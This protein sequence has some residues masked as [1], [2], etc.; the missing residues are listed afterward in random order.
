MDEVAA[1]LDT[2]GGGVYR[3]FAMRRNVSALTEHPDLQ[4]FLKAVASETRQRILFLFVDGQARTVGQVA[5]ELE[6]V[7]S[8]ASEHLSI[9]KRG[10]LVQA[11][12]E[13]KEVFY[14]PDRPRVLALLKRLTH[15]LT[16]CCPT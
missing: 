11:E 14:R 10:G 1:G 3:H 12:R 4:E 2:C 13:G 5:S 15:F 7:P 6:I 8:T 16:D 9:L